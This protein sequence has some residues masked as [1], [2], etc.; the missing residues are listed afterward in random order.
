MSCVYMNICIYVYMYICINNVVSLGI[1]LAVYIR[2]VGDH[3][4]INVFLITIK[5]AL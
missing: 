5:H 4:N 3:N 1:H 2:R